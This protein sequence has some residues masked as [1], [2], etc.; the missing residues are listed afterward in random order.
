MIFSCLESAPEN[1]LSTSSLSSCR[2]GI[3]LIIWEPPTEAKSMRLCWCTSQL[4][5]P[6]EWAI[7]S[8]RISSIVIWLRG[9]VWLV[10]ITWWRWVILMLDKQ[11]SKDHVFRSLILVWRGWYRRER[12]PTLLNQEQSSPSSG[13]HP[14]VWLTTSSQPSQMSGPSVFFCGK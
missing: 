13:Q 9:I 7:L 6:Q 8:P 2:E 12:T 10:I 1:H 4:R 14:R 5:L 11:G 3:F